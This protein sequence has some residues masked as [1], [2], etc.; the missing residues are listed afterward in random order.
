MNELIQKNVII[1][2]PIFVADTLV[3]LSWIFPVIISYIGGK[4][5][6]GYGTKRF[7]TLS[8]DDEI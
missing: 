4:E 7:G 8:N 2:F 6:I 1:L 5:C 3:L